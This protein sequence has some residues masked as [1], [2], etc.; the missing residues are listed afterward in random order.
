MIDLGPLRGSQL[1]VGTSDSDAVPVV[2]TPVDGSRSGP[3]F[4]LDLV[5]GDVSDLGPLPTDKFVAN[6]YAVSV[7]HST[8]L[9]TDLCDQ[10]P[11]VGE[12]AG[13][14][15]PSGDMAW[16]VFVRH[17]QTWTALDDAG[18]EP[19]T[20]P[21]TIS[22]VDGAVYL[23][24]A[25]PTGSTGS[26]APTL[27]VD[28]QS[29]TTHPASPPTSSARCEFSTDNSAVVDSAA[30]T[31]RF[32]AAPG[33]PPSTV[34]LDQLPA[35]FS[36]LAGGALGLLQCWSS[37]PYLAMGAGVASGP[38]SPGGTGSPPA[39]ASGGLASTTTVL[40]SGSASGSV[41]P[42]TSQPAQAT[43]LIDLRHPERPPVQLDTDGGS[44]C[45]ISGVDYWGWQGGAGVVHL[46]SPDGPVI[47]DV[48]RSVG[49]I[50][51]T[52]HAVGLLDADSTGAQALRVIRIP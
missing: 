6:G 51:A 43:V 50:I 13:F 24:P 45:L 40:A 31:V 2:R 28:L 46:R 37:G 8:V 34:G 49:S 1:S 27:A 16:Q 26:T 41:A 36:T 44:C 17:G 33:A 18:S 32:R 39:A 22:V 35:P 29:L 52:P 4:T 20:F 12:D 7:G 38:P 48:R 25:P 23:V 21:P 10:A 9:S 42:T 5:S 11:T 15:C 14:D 19:A 47:A 30:G 3:V